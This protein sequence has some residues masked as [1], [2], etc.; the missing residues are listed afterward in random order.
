MYVTDILITVI[1]CKKKQFILI[2]HCL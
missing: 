1:V 2:F